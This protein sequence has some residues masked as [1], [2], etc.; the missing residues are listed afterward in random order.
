MNTATPATQTSVKSSL[1][2]RVAA[3]GPGI[4]VV[5]GAY[6]HQ[7]LFVNRLFQEQFAY[8]E[9]EVL[10]MN[11]SDMLDPYDRERFY[12]QVA[13]LSTDLHAIQDFVV[14]RLR[15]KDGQLKPFYAYMS[16]C[17]VHGDGSVPGCQI[18]LIPDNMG[19]SIPYTSS[20]TKELFLKHFAAEG[21]GTF[22]WIIDIDKVFWS[23]G[24][25][26]I[27]DVD[28][29]VRDVTLQFARRFVHPQDRDRV[30][31]ATRGENGELLDVD[32]EFRIVTAHN[33]VKTIHSLG[34]VIRDANGQPIKYIGSVRDITG[35]RAMEDHLRN[36]MEELKRS[37][38]ELEDF[39]YAASHDLQEPLRKITTFSGRL[40]DKFKAALAGEGEMY[41]ERMTASAENMRQLITSLLEFSRITQ[42]QAPFTQVSLSLVI[43]QVM[44]DL[45]LKIEET[46]T[47]VNFGVLPVVDAV[48]THIK[49][50]FMNLISNAIKFHKPGEAPVITITS[51]PLADDELQ[52]LGLS[53][54]RHYHKVTVQDNGIGFE[55]EYANR[56][57]QVFQRLHGKSEFPGSGVGLAICKKILE[58]HSGVIYAES[59]KGN[60][61]K[62]TIV[63]PDR[64]S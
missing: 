26:R 2:E 57:F 22:E 31:A 29:S 11:F 12:R 63:I 56:I 19:W 33:V 47:V 16:G 15:R 58:H 40:R 48:A 7:I 18:F 52:M 39:A 17:D 46:G 13:K 25:Y 28:P 21:Y 54:K 41:L 38:K 49:Q 61:A 35:R 59:S 23:A 10:G 20:E 44:S 3:G 36:K 14:Y 50:L 37:N 43:K 5:V 45:E 1:A 8:S 60:G 6:D 55:Q 51:Q 32:L 24:I 62:F 34:K 9:D 42:S 4:T 27:Y 64:Q 30:A 53:Q